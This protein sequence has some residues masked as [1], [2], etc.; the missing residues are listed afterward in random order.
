MK[1]SLDQGGISV[2]VAICFHFILLYE[3][4]MLLVFGQEEFV[5][6]DGALLIR[7]DFT[8]ML[9]LC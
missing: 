3:H 8:L 2:S 1:H 4:Q 7:E 9:I 5:H 6:L